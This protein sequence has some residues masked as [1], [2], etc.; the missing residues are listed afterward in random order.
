MKTVYER[1]HRAVDRAAKGLILDEFCETYRCHRKHALRLLKSP[2]SRPPR[3]PRG[4][5]SKGIGA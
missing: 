2:D 3:R 4:L 5:E 1:Y